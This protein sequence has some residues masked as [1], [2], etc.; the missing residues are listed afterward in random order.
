MAP[1]PEQYSVGFVSTSKGRIYW[2]DV[3]HND[4]DAPRDFGPAS[5][6]PEADLDAAID[7]GSLAVGSD[8]A[9]AKAKAELAKTGTVPPQA[10]IGMSLIKM[11]SAPDSKPGVWEVSFLNG[12][13][14]EGMRSAEV[15]GKTGQVTETTKK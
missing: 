4:A 5:A 8:E 1:P 14:T 10:M 7:Y 12:T 11:P 13:S 3:N 15:D 2:V 6:I 9:Y